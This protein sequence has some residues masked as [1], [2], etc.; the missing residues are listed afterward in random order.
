VIAGRIAQSFADGLAAHLDVE[1]PAAR[2]EA[3]ALLLATIE[4]LLMLR[5]VG[6]EAVVDAAVARLRDARAAR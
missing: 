1:P 3:A 5:S 6:S 4:G 2:A